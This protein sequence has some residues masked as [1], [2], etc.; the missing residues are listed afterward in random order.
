MQTDNKEKQLILT[1]GVIGLNNISGRFNGYTITKTGVIY[2][3][4]KKT[5]SKSI[6]L[7]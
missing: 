2:P 1:G 3:T 6:K 7:K 4:R 5:G